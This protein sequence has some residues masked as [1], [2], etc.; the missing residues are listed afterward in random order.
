MQNSDCD[1]RNFDSV[2]PAF[3]LSCILFSTNV[4]IEYLFSVKQTCIKRSQALHS[5]PLGV[6]GKVPSLPNFLWA[7][8]MYYYHYCQL[9]ITGTTTIASVNS[10]YCLQRT[11]VQTV[12]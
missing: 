12:M 2:K 5:G 11:N 4:A 10:F 6:R 1:H 8:A 3:T 7:W 9:I